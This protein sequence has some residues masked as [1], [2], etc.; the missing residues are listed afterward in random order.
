MIEITDDLRKERASK[1]FSEIPASWLS[2]FI[3]LLADEIGFDRDELIL[4]SI[5][6]W[7]KWEKPDVQD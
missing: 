2:S 3:T 5:K 4:I 7:H 1:L 6:M